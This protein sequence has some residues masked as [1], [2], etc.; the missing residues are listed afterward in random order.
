MGIDFSEVTFQYKDPNPP[1]EKA[2]SDKKK[3]DKK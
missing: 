2:D 3:I 1:S